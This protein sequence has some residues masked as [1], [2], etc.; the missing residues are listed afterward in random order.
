[1]ELD[2]SAGRRLGLALLAALVL[3]FAIPGAA[4]AQDRDCS[5]FATQAEARAFLSP[6]D[7]HGLDA[8]GDGIP[9]ENLP[10]GTGQ[11]VRLADTGLDAWLIG[12]GGVACL[13]GAMAL[14]RRP[15]GATIA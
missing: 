7:P 5:D 4:Q 3:V 14:R 13:L 2:I 11:R 15:R 12:V 10:V 8:D 6:G 1:M 9:C